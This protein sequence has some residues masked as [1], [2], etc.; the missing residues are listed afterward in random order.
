MCTTDTDRDRQHRIGSL[1][2]PPPHQTWQH[3]VSTGGDESPREV[4]NVQGGEHVREAPQE[5]ESGVVVA[6]AIDIEEHR[7]GGVSSI[8]VS[9]AVSRS[10]D[11]KDQAFGVGFGNRNR[12]FGG[13]DFC[14]LLHC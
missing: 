14:Q 11:E 8:A 3:E 13:K 9:V 4:G 7:G 10:V 5:K 6:F 1:Q 2:K 12:G